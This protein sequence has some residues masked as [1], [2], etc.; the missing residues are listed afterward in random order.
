MGI[1][2]GIY[3]SGLDGPDTAAVWVRYDADDGITV[4]AAWEDHGQ[5]ADIGAVGTAHEALRPMLTK[6]LQFMADYKL[7]VAVQNGIKTNSITVRLA[8][9]F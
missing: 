4:G 7:P 5:G 6:Q 3:G 1:A 2:L 9:V 8:Y